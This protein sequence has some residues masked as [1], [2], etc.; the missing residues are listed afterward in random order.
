VVADF[1]GLAAAI[2][3]VAALTFFSGLVVVRA[4]RRPSPAPF[5]AGA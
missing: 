4:M 5:A 1:V 2:H 3:L